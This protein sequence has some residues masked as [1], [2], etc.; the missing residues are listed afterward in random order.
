M[1]NDIPLLYLDVVNYPWPHPDVGLADL[2]QLKRLKIFTL[3]NQFSH[4]HWMRENPCRIYCSSM[5]VSRTLCLLFNYSCRETPYHPHASGMDH[6]LLLTCL[7]CLGVPDS[8]IER[9]EFAE[10]T[11]ASYRPCSNINVDLK[12]KDS[13]YKDKTIGRSSY[14]RF[15][16]VLFLLQLMT[17]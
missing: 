4:Q 8:R 2:C 17:N 7:I 3:L 11:S 10:N 6:S 12:Y 13:H 1:S 16:E 15:G 14:P 9:S 5:W